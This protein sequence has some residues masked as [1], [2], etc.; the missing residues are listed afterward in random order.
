MSSHL[1]S[2]VSLRFC[3]AGFSSQRVSRGLDVCCW[4][5]TPLCSSRSVPSRCRRLW[6]GLATAELERATAVVPCQGLAGRGV[7]HA[8]LTAASPRN[9]DPA[10]G[11]GGEP[12]AGNVWASQL[13][14]LCGE[15]LEPV[16]ASLSH[17]AE[18]LLLVARCGAA[19]LH[20]IPLLSP[21]FQVLE[22]HTAPQGLVKPLV[23]GSFSC[24]CVTI[25]LMV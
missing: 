5:N 4:D 23:F 21:E 9:S 2:L 22:E 20:L 24:V 7:G 19:R 6:P 10:G 8:W 16:L 25:V 14:Q 3:G 12:A 1:S 15:E 17:P 13:L 18:L 11:A